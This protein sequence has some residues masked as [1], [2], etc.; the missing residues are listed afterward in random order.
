[1]IR[2]SKFQRR[3]E[4]FAKFHPYFARQ[5]AFAIRKIALA[6]FYFAFR[7]RNASRY[8]PTA[9]E[10][11][12][13]AGHEAIVPAR[14]EL[15]CAFDVE[16]W[17]PTQTRLFDHGARRIDL[18]PSGFQFGIMRKRVCDRVVSSQARFLIEVP[19]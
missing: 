6:Y 2:E 14:W 15:A 11:Q 5:Y 8:A 13:N 7:N 16:H 9:F 18:F 1:M 10:R 17:V 12:R 4:R 3:R 19:I